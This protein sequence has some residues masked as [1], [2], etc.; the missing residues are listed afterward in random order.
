MIIIGHRGAC[1]YELE[2][3]MDSFEK[4]IDLGVDYV[5][6]DIQRTLDDKII[7][8]HDKCLP[9]KSPVEELTLINLKQESLKLGF[10]IPTL[11]EVLEFINCRTGVNIEIKSR[12]PAAIVLEKIYKYNCDIDKVI[13]SS[14]MQDRI[15]DIKNNDAKIKTGLIL[16]ER[17]VGI[18]GVLSKLGSKIV[19]QDHQF[20]DREYIDM[21]HR[22]NI[23]VFVWTV[24]EP[25]DIANMIEMK[26]DGIISDFPDRIKSF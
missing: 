1:G 26:V 9:N 17:V 2:N 11:D 19:I 24:N 21:L 10:N 14:F 12:I 18:F 20:I 13:V 23:E 16:N 8:F 4:A 5:E 3:T 7:V 22:G 25:E 15:L 6:F